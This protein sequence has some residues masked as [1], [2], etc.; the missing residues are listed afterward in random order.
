M[1]FLM[2]TYLMISQI[3]SKVTKLTKCLLWVDLYECEHA[4][5]HI[6][7]REW[8][9]CWCG[10]KPTTYTK[11]IA[12]DLIE[13]TDYLGA[14]WNNGLWNW[15]LKLNLLRFCKWEQGGEYRKASAVIW[16]MFI[17]STVFCF[18]TSCIQILSKTGPTN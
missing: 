13:F 11:Y 17:F 4:H 8:I 18:S 7:W 6:C 1:W 14:F 10:I 9:S 12:R 16:V 2:W 15:W 5:V 3:F